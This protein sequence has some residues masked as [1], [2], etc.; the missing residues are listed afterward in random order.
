MAISTARPP[1][2]SER[3]KVCEPGVGGWRS[4]AI[5]STPSP[6]VLVRDCTPSEV[7]ERSIGNKTERFKWIDRRLARCAQMGPIIT[8]VEDIDELLPRLETRQVED[9]LVDNRLFDIQLSLRHSDASAVNEL[10]FM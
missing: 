4:L 9:S 6:A 8:E 3:W 7:W 5:V 2:R 10:E 1:A